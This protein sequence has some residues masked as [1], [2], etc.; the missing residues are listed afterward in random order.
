MIQVLA[1]LVG[2][3][4]ILSIFTGPI[5]L[6][7]TVPAAIALFFVLRARQSEAKVDPRYLGGPQPEHAGGRDDPSGANPH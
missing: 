2:A 1:A 4:I 6:V 3:G 5:G 7:L